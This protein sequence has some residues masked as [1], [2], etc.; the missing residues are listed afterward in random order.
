MQ[1]DYGNGVLGNTYIIVDL[2]YKDDAM[3]PV[4]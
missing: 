4:S 3:A 2:Y 1:R